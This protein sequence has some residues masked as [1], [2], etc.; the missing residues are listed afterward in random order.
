M[1]LFPHT[2][3]IA[4]CV[5]LLIIGFGHS[6]RQNGRAEQDVSVETE[7]PVY[8]SIPDSTMQ[9]LWNECDYIDFV[10]YNLSYSMSQDQQSD[11]R[12][13]L[14]H[15]SRKP[16][17]TKPDCNP[18]GRIFF[19]IEGENAV[20]AD[21]FFSPECRYFIFYKDNKKTY[22]NAMTPAGIQFYERVLQMLER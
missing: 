20:Q 3:L 18:L 11:I 10:F 13:T 16:A 4:C 7:G 1:P 15:V 21:I 12:S 9:R 8:S 19:Q 2:R 5:L 14:R 22:A 17:D 6:C